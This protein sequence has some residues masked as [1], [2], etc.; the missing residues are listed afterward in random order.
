SVY[1]LKAGKACGMKTVAVSTGTHT[2]SELKKM[3]PDLL[4]ESLTETSAS[5]I[6]S[7]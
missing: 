3:Q 1:G 5:Q 7:L 4:L 6:L 2:K